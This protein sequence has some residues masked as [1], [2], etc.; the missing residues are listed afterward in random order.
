MVCHVCQDGMD[1]PASITRAP[2]GYTSMSSCTNLLCPRRDALIK[3]RKLISTYMYTGDVYRR[4]Y[5]CNREKEV[6][7][8]ST[9]QG[10]GF[11]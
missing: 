9:C 1:I 2:S 4:K 6:G 10:S 5:A 7:L 3:R 8:L 11:I